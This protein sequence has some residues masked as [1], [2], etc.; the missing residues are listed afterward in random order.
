MDGRTYPWGDKNPICSLVNYRNCVDNPKPVGNLLDNASPYGVLDMAGNVW[1]WVADWYEAGYYDASPGTNPTGP[2][3]GSTRII[4]GGSWKGSNEFNLR[5]SNREDL[6]PTNTNDELGFR[7]IFEADEHDYVVEAEPETT[8]TP[9]WVTDFAEPILAY[10]EERPPYVED[11]FASKNAAWDGLRTDQGDSMIINNN[12]ALINATYKNKSIN[13]FDYVVGVTLHH[14]SDIYAGFELGNSSAVDT[15]F[16][17]RS[18][19]HWV[20]RLQWENYLFGDTDPAAS[21]RLQVIVKGSHFAFIIN[22]DPVAYFEYDDFRLYR[23]D[24][25]VVA[26]SSERGEAVFSNFKAWN[27]TSFDVPTE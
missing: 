12:Q 1:E 2:G 18:D 13:F 8:P 14:N 15:H 27:I 7:C 10:I 23:G 3:S 4:R 20:V 9:D 16:Y 22:S 17:I 5:T 24:S 11:Q 21:Y 19:G 6:N 25:P 26:L